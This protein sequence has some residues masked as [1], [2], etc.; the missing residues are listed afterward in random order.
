MLRKIKKRQ[1]TMFRRYFKS[2]ALIIFCAFLF[3]GFTMMVFVSG[4]WWNE[5][6]ETLTRNARN[7]S[8]SYVDILQDDNSLF[9]EADYF[10]GK[11]NV[12]DSLDVDD[13]MN[14]DLNG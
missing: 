13:I 11:D 14:A 4:Q 5:K 1:S 2:A 3:Y 6:V 7:I 9:E 10:F 8:D 12:A